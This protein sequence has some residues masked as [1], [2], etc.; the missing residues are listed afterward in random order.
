MSLETYL[1]AKDKSLNNK[2]YEIKLIKDGSIGP[3][4]WREYL[5]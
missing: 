3:E 4:S 2:Q 5:W 1:C